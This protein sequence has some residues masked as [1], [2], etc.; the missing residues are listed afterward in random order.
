MPSLVYKTHWDH[1]KES[2]GC[3]AV[4]GE[5]LRVARKKAGLS[6]RALSK[7]AGNIVTAQ[8]LGK[9][10][11]NEMVASAGVVEALTSALGVE[12]TFL[13]ADSG[14]RLGH[15]DFRKLSRTTAQDR[16]AVEAAV[17]E[18]VERYLHIEKLLDLE[19]AAWIAP[20]TRRAV[21]TLK[22]AESAADDARS[23]WKLGED[24]IPNLTHLLEEKGLKVLVL[25]L[26]NTVSGLTCLVQSSGGAATPVIIVNRNHGLERRRM[27]LAHELAHRCITGIDGLDEEKAATRFASAFLMPSSHIQR[28][29]GKHRR[30]FDVAELMET[31]HLYRVSAAA[32]VVRFRDLEIITPETMAYIFQSVGRKWRSVEPE[33]IKNNAEAELPT[34][35]RRLCHRALSE[36]LLGNTLASRYLEQPAKELEC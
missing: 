27:T 28:E 10:E 36:G 31:K 3:Q 11:R 19:S 20:Y 16:A 2:A 12:P 32:L 23:A 22:Q 25:A 13:S 1:R 35:F 17:I 8:A 9:Y 33:P 34:R 14:I 15:I 26:P 6:L 30:A 4:K 24:P 18:H 29:I 7:R 5:R 21:D